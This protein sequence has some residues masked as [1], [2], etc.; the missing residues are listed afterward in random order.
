MERQRNRTTKRIQMVFGLTYGSVVDVRVQIALGG[1]PKNHDEHQSKRMP[2][3]HVFLFRLNVFERRSSN[4]I[5]MMNELKSYFTASFASDN[6][7]ETQKWIDQLLIEFIGF[8]IFSSSL[9]SKGFSSPSPERPREA[10]CSCFFARSAKPVDAPMNFPGILTLSRSPTCWESG[11]K[12]E[13][14]VTKTEKANLTG[15]KG[16]WALKM[17]AIVEFTPKQSKNHGKNLPICCC[18]CCLQP[19]CFLRA[20]TSTY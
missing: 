18:C 7:N 12:D 11:E 1:P 14:T 17:V 20:R 10:F 16:P 6:S 13:S 9:E 15:R 5:R 19:A 2:D 8:L 4:P 3:F